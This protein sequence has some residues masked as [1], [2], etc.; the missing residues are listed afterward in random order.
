MT[1]DTSS[2]DRFIRVTRSNQA[3]RVQPQ[4]YRKGVA[5][6][7]HLA[8]LFEVPTHFRIVYSTSR[9]V[10]LV[11]LPD[12]TWIV[13][14]Q[15]LGQSLNLL[16]R[17]FIEAGDLEPAI[18]YFHKVLAE[19]LVE[20]GRLE[21]A[22]H[23]AAFYDEHRDLLQPR[24]LDEPWRF[25]LTEVHETF[26]M[27]HE[28]GHRLYDQE[29]ALPETREQVAELIAAQITSKQRSLE[30]Q[31][32]DLRN[33]PAAAIHH[34]DVEDVINDVQQLAQAPD[35]F[36]AAQLACLDDP[37]T[38]EEVFCDI[39]AADLVMAAMTSEGADPIQVL[40]AI[41]IGFYHIQALEY[42]KRFP[43]L[44]GS[45]TDWATDIVP[46]VQTRAH[47]LQDHLKFL[48]GV[49]LLSNGSDA[50]ELPAATARLGIA[51]FEDQKRHYESVYDAAMNLCDNLRKD[52]W[53]EELGQAAMGELHD[54][55]GEAG[56]DAI[57]ADRLKRLVL[58]MTG[59]LGDPA[60]ATPPAPGAETE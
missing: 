26:L 59:W 6:L 20:V 50:A 36:M 53:I 40:R 5:R 54:R 41:Y 29:N 39:F 43:L 46:R 44:A 28:L 15:Y 38:F 56:G 37:Q 45:E 10:E 21:Q 60:P 33:A 4:L 57:T 19:R 24:R 12:A 35:T 13:Y 42:L 2:I 55:I 8:T 18:I 9:R 30:D 16:N 48:Y 49:Y 25:L 34:R 7:S 23:C 32:R 17:L 22:L 14:D 11:T 47:C 31:V 51:L 3:G 27:S 52:N 1:T 58:A